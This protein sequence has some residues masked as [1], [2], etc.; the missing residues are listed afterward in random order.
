MNFMSCMVL[1]RSGLPQATLC[2]KCVESA[3]MR[4]DSRKMA[5]R[6]WHVLNVTSLFVEPAMSTREVKATSVVLSATLAI[7]DTKVVLE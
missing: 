5:T 3:E 1:M 6:L 7:S 4:L 2:P